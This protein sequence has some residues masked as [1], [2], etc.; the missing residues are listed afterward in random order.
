MALKRGQNEAEIMMEA[1]LKPVTKPL[2]EILKKIESNEV[3]EDKIMDTPIKKKK[4]EKYENLPASTID[5][6]YGLK[7]D[8]QQQHQ[9]K[10]GSKRVDINDNDDIVI[11]GIMYD[12][13]DGLYELLMKKKP[14][15]YNHEDLGNYRKILEKTHAHRQNYLADGPLVRS[16]SYKYVKIIKKLFTNDLNL[17]SGSGF[18]TYIKNSAVD[19]V[20]FDSPDELVDRLRLLYASRKSGSSAHTNEIISILEELREAKVIE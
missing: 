19:Y 17:S 20:Y 13:T 7:R 8:R 5:E 18:K 3:N 2:R 9:W 16:K 1:S 6:R 4:F 14:K 15:K 12:G 10:I 11:D